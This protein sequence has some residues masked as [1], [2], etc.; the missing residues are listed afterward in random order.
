[1]SHFRLWLRGKHACSHRCVRPCVTWLQLERSL[2]QEFPEERMFLERDLLALKQQAAKRLADVQTLIT[3][4][5][6]LEQSLT[7]SQAGKRLRGLGASRGGRC[8]QHWCAP[9]CAGTR[10][11]CVSAVESG[12]AASALPYAVLLALLRNYAEA[13][14]LELAHL[15]SPART[16]RL[17]RPQCLWRMDPSTSRMFS[18]LS[19]L[20]LP[21]CCRRTPC[22]LVPASGAPRGCVPVC[23]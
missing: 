22:L 16:R 10:D 17:H 1:M 19:S 23:F 12:L 13:G 15:A 6:T 20:T 4:R 8:E 2:S 7:S 21:S 9:T 18:V 14:L 5:H 3:L 11:E